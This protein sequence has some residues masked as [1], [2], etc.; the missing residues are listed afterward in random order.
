MLSK[1]NKEHRHQLQM[2]TVD[3]LV[4]A[5]HLVRKI[6]ASIDLILFM[7]SLRIIIAWIKDVQVLIQLY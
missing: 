7:I 5:D 3:D 2:V 4:P 1:H 6:E